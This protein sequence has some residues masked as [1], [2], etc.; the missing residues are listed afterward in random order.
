[1]EKRSSLKAFLHG[2]IDYA[3]LFPP[4]KLPL[5][6]AIKN[7]TAYINCKDAWMLRPF[8]LPAAKLFEIKEYAQLFEEKRPLRLS[9]AGSKT[10]T[11]REFLSQLKK[12][13]EQIG[14]FRK[15]YGDW[16]KV[17]VLE[18]PL[19]VNVPSKE[20]LHEV[21]NITREIGVNVFCEIHL[22]KE[23]KWE[24][25][26]TNSLDVIASLNSE[27]GED[28]GIK[29]RTGGIKAELI[30][31]PD[32]LAFAIAQCRDR[33]LAMKF[34]AGLHHPVRMYREEVN[35]KMHGF[36]N[37]F[38]ASMLAYELKLNET[39]VKAILLDE[40]PSHFKITDETIGWQQ[41]VL[42]PEQISR[43]RKSVCSFGSC[44]FDEPT[45][46]LRELIGQQE[47]T[48]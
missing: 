35:A 17:E 7:Y 23:N 3:G 30:P 46:E 15:R 34:T 44:S 39:I 41:L 20:F 10:E 2:L 16:L 31:D 42:S 43:L 13:V 47:V 4:A 11:E 21:A 14:Y 24:D 19:P 37:V 5:D 29:W 25:H 48:A 22:L 28:F 33:D 1:M 36:L 32:R 38:I 27:N 45:D 26:V 18:L 12:D 9:I 40:D 8:V 6:Q